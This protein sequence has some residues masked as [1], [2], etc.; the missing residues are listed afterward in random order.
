VGTYR[1]VTVVVG[2][3]YHAGALAALDGL[4]AGATLS[5]QRE[6]TNPHDPNA[7]AVYSED[8]AMLGHVPRNQAALL[9]THMDCGAQMAC[10]LIGKATRTIEIRW[11]TGKPDGGVVF[12]KLPP[13]E[14]DG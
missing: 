12:A 1:T 5:L 9:A 8:G 6:P 3:C 7:V 14:G 4:R 10:A 13:Y 2:S 11:D